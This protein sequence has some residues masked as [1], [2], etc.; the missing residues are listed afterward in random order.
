MSLQIYYILKKNK[1]KKL[2][3]VINKK[4]K[5]FSN[6]ENLF[7]NKKK[8]YNASEIKYISIIINCEN[9][10]FSY[11][12]VSNLIS[13]L[14]N[15]TFK[16][17]Q[18]IVLLNSSFIKKKNIILNFH[19]INKNIKVYIS[20][21]EF[22]LQRIFEIINEIKTK[23]IIILE[24]FIELKND[25]LFNIYN[26]IKGNINN[27]LK[28]PIKNGYLYLMRTKILRDIF[29]S[30]IQFSNYKELINFIFS[31]PLPKINYIPISY[32]PNNVY[33][34]LVYT[35]MLSV[36]NSKE[37]YSYILFYIVVSK[38]F[39]EQNKCFLESLYE[40]YDYFNITFIRMDDRYKNAFTAS[41]LTIHAYYRYSLGELIPN[42]NKI[43]YLDADTICLTDL[44]NLYNLNFRGKVILGRIL[45]SGKSI[46]NKCPFI[47]TGVL[48][49]D[50]LGM[51]KMKFEKKVLNILKDGFGRKKI[52]ERKIINMGTN[53]NTQDQALI[54]IYFNKYTG[55]LPPKYNAK[56]FHYKGSIFLNNN[57]DNF[58]DDYLYFSFKYPSIKHFAGPKKNIVYIDDWNY[59]ARKSKYFNKITNNFS[60]IYNFSFVC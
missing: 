47:N 51:R 24:K 8:L 53:L 22:W 35:S 57:S 41:Y 36:L 10:K 60:N 9:S 5:K 52:P 55:P 50:L 37:Y 3:K 45:S 56:I 39:K 4:K 23:Y 59:F 18:I 6:F 26:K 31:Y 46:K 1:E 25:D 49:L 17:I 14:L 32:C 34:A 7:R 38:D 15:Q 28:Y 54:N 48:L 29:D 13:S 27:I 20:E 43:I 40:Q 33:T 30:K 11:G 21:Y 16:D 58:Y 44:S 19:R 12:N 42:L 2:P